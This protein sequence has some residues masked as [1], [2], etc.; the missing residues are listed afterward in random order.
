MLAISV[1]RKNSFCFT[2]A[3]VFDATTLAAVVDEL[4]EKILHGRVQEIVQLDALT[5]GF[6]IYA[7]HERRYLYVTAH[8]DDTRVHLVAQKLRSAGESPSPLLLALRKHAENAQK[9]FNKC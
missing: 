5:F 8:P 6:E 4:N 9:Y 3:H 7:A 1:L 2:I